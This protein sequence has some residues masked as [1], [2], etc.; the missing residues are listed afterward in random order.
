MG[1]PFDYRLNADS[2]AR[3]EALEGPSSWSREPGFTYNGGSTSSPLAGLLATV[4]NNR[5]T[6]SFMGLDNKD[7]L[8]CGSAEGRGLEKVL[9]RCGSR[10]GPLLRFFP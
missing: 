3:P 6:L 4:I 7:V 2:T 1:G 9:W 10:F 8:T 5:M